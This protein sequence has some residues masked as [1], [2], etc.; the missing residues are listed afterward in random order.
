MVTESSVFVEDTFKRAQKV[1]V[2]KSDGCSQGACV[3]RSCD[4]CDN[5]QRKVDL[6]RKNSIQNVR[7]GIF[8][9]TLEWVSCIQLGHQQ[10]N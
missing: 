9:E 8:H 10:F 6:P 1:S 3:V 4:G 2:C 7:G 5:P